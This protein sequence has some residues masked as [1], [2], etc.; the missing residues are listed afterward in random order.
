M[1]FNQITQ[2]DIT[3]LA[4]LGQRLWPDADETELRGEFRIL[5]KSNR[6][7]AFICRSQ[8][9]L[10]AGFVHISMRSDFVEGTRTTP[11]GYLE[12]IYVGPAFRNKGIGKELIRLGEEWARQQG[13]TEFAGD[14]EL[15]NRISQRFIE[16]AGFKE[17][18]RL[19]CYTKSLR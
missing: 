11:V 7:T 16:K 10:A 12:G 17:V 9:G 19:V 6:D 13:C 18:N 4:R 2:S 8:S 15:H 3:D 1:T 5:L 14:V